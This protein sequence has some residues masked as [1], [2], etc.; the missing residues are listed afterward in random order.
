MRNFDRL[1]RVLSVCVCVMLAVTVVCAV[2][3][4]VFGPKKH[5]YSQKGDGTQ[6]S[7]AR[8][9]KTYEYSDTYV[10]FIV[11]YGDSTMADIKGQG[12]LKNDDF[13]LTG[14]YGET[15]LDL[16][17]A[18]AETDR[19]DADG[20]PQSIVLAVSDMK[21]QYLL[22]TVG[23]ENGV[24]HCSEQVF[25]QYYSALVD[26]I[27]TASPQTKIILQSVFPVSRAVERKT[28]A[29]SN[30][31]ID[32]ANVWIEEIAEQHGVRYLNTAEALKDGKGFLDPKYDRGDGI[33]LN[34]KGYRAVIQYIRSHGYK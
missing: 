4:G 13:I 26:S 24:A 11:F 17:T 9:D 14:A 29:I 1:S 31:K 6:R 2:L 16:N 28:P 10:D 8:L 25:K 7:S 22:I 30:D 19:R 33:H 32:E 27:K 3:L 21:P 23:I 15:P 20:D 5:L 18:N 34:E 12:L